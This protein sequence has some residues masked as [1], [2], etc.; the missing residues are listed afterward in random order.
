MKIDVDE[1]NKIDAY[2]GD[3]GSPKPRYEGQLTPSF[4]SAL[5]DYHA[6]VTE[7]DAVFYHTIDFSDGVL[8]KGAWD[9]RDHEQAYLGGC[10]VGGKR[11][12]EVGPASGFLSAYLA[13]KGADLVV[14]DLPLGSASELVPFSEID[15]MDE[16]ATGARRSVEQLRNSWWL[17]K[18]KLGF[19]A[20]A[21]YAD[22]Y[23]PP[24]DLGRFDVTV[25][26]SILL[27]L[28]NPF[29]ALQAFAATTDSTIVVTDVLGVQSLSPE[30][31]QSL[32]GSANM[33]FA[34][35]PLPSGIVH[36]WAL[37]P[38]A[39]RHMLHK[40][41]FTECVVTTHSPKRMPS[42]PPLFTV[43]ARRAPKSGL[44]RKF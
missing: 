31:G 11:V 30:T 35:S 7:Q 5:E 6:K 32:Y 10:D 26:G 14:F 2:F 3:Q 28:A 15:D 44:K 42:S 13:S 40:L 20:S 17:T 29:R 16:F 21:V 43:V 8:R 33:I 18:R 36:W 9:L 24:S 38:N 22:I 25:F 19:K 39:I 12:L 27:H 41:G 1:K 34:P 37:S 4:Q 23:A